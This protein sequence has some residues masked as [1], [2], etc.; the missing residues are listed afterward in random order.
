MRLDTLQKENTEHSALLEVKRI[1]IELC[2]LY[3]LQVFNVP[4]FARILVIGE[5]VKREKDTLC[6][7]SHSLCYPITVNCERVCADLKPRV[8]R[9]ITKCFPA[10]VLLVAFR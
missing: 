2:N 7:C 3:L 10:N 4:E 8:A 1:I 9:L 6:S 5:C